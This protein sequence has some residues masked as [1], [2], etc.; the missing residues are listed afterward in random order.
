MRGGTYFIVMILFILRYLY[1]R[2]KSYMDQKR[3]GKV[4]GRLGKGSRNAP[5]LRQ[6]RPSTDK[7]D[8][9]R[10]SEQRQHGRHRGTGRV[11]SD[12]QT[13]VV[14]R[15]ARPP[16][17]RRLEGRRRR[18][19]RR[20]RSVTAGTAAGRQPVIIRRSPELTGVRRQMLNSRRTSPRVS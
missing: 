2:F 19:Y 20:R 12:E 15:R 10:R 14:A 3:D 5:A 1:F 9:P 13:Q 4:G 7:A 18:S 11:P 6:I 16:A 17:G 8:G